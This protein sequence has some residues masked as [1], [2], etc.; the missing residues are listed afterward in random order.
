ML[1]KRK[2]T[3]AAT[4]IGQLVV[5]KLLVLVPPRVL[6]AHGHLQA[7]PPLP[8][9]LLVPQVLGRLRAEQVQVQVVHRADQVLRDLHGWP[10]VV[11]KPTVVDFRLA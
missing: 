6:L 3:H 9:P 10:A 5:R 2:Q 1:K 11:R 7:V 4:L 8:V